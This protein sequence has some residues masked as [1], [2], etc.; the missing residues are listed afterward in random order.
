MA[1]CEPYQAIARELRRIFY[2]GVTC[3]LLHFR[4]ITK[5]AVD[6]VDFSSEA[7]GKRIKRRLWQLIRKQW[8]I[9]P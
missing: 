8:W 6:K 9:Q 4:K 5:A 2:R 7:R 1:C 3:S